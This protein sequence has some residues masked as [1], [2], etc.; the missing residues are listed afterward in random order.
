MHVRRGLGIPRRAERRGAAPF[1]V[2]L[3]ISADELEAELDK[4]AEERGA[5]YYWVIPEE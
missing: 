4:P 3:P 5:D 1:A 2:V